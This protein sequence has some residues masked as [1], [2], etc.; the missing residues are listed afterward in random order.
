MSVF[1]SILT[2]A[3][4]LGAA[5]VGGIFFAFS[6]FI[7]RALASVPSPAGLQ[8]MQSINIKVLNPGFLGLFM[9]TA[10]IFVVLASVALLD[11]SAAQS[12]YLLGAAVA[13]LGGTWGVTVR[14]NVPLNDQ[15][16]RQAPEGPDSE[17]IWNDYVE[18]WTRLNSQR[19]GA[20]I[21]AAFLLHMA[22]WP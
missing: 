14:G 16:A 5:L 15:L 3:A 12:P 11:W 13:Y 19:T 1:V 4:L 20:S 6:N 7:M 21:L 10:L 9:G 18:G 22:I 8:A 2:I 17:Q